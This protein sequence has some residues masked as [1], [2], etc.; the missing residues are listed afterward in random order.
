MSWLMQLVGSGLVLAALGDVYTTVLFARSGTGL[1]SP[2]L[3]RGVWACLRRVARAIPDGRRRLLPHSGPILLVLNLLLWAALLIGGF[4]LIVW[5]ELGSGIQSSGGQPTPRTFGAALYFAGYNLTTLGVGDLIPQSDLLRVLTVVQAGLGFSLLTLS[6]T[7]FMS[8]YSA[9]ARRNRFALS[10]HHQTADSGDA[11]EL[12]AQLATADGDAAQRELAEIEAG[13]DDLYESHH[14]YSVLHYF[15]FAERHYAMSQI[16]QVAM[17]TATLLRSTL[18]EREHRRLLE[19]SAVEG[20]WRSGVYL[21]DGLA[22]SLLPQHLQ[23]EAASGREDIASWE[24]DYRD[25][26]EK[27]KTCGVAV[28]GDQQAGLIRYEELRRVWTGKINAFAR[29]MAADSP[30]DRQRR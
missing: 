28:R 21:L 7:Y 16:L 20:L 12:V 6:L 10:L 18:D 22:E 29:H 23:Q 17:E 2:W 4:A 9:L 26:V 15:Y 1:F 13:L 27:L 14:F 25:A 11:T 19:S 5:P 30:H 8:V 24:A 3:Y